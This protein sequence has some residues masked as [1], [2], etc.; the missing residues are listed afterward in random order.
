MR[1]SL[2]YDLLRLSLFLPI[3]PLVLDLHL[4]EQTQAGTLRENTQIQ[5]TPCV[6]AL[7]PSAKYTLGSNLLFMFSHHTTKHLVLFSTPFHCVLY[8]S[9]IIL[10]IC[11]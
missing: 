3:C 6:D 7:Y 11:I 2:S 5:I 9:S 4:H 1:V 8:S 10:H